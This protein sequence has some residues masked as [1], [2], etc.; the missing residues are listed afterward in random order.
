MT[1]SIHEESVLLRRKDGHECPATFV[2]DED[3][4]PLCTLTL[5]YAEHEIVAVEDDYFEAMRTIRKQLALDGI[6]PV[7]YGASRNC[8]P[9]G[10]SREMGQAILVYRM[11]MGIQAKTEDLVSIFNSGTDVDPVTVEEQSAFFDEWLVGPRRAR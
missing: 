10:M 6:V 7:C 2:W 5:R 1:D 8:F 9:S 11:T 4:F 3:E